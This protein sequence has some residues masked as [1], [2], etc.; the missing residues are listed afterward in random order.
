MN[1]AK[2]KPASLASLLA[3]VCAALL[4]PSGAVAAN[5]AVTQTLDEI[6]EKGSIRIAVYRDFPPFSYRDKGQLKGVDVDIAS[7]IAKGLGVKLTF[8]ELTPDETVDDDLRN[9]VWKGHYMG[10][11]VANIMM[12]VPYDKVFAKRNNLVVIL[13]PYYD[14]RLAIAWDKNKVGDSQT[15]AIF[16]YEKVGVE[17]DSLPD[18]YLSSAFGGQFQK[19]VVHFPRIEDAAQALIDKKLAAIMAPVSQISSSLGDKA[20]N[21]DINMPPAPGLTKNSWLVGVSVSHKARA[22]GYAVGDVIAKMV[23]NGRMEAIFKNHGLDYTPPPLS[24]LDGG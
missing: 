5:E 11:G 6:V 8:M 12:H 9:A 1:F 19:N 7:E 23:R 24:L 21:Y 13:G 3:F 20:T 4:A 17:L 14:E 22:L 18:F 15:M 2:T 16:G 10:G